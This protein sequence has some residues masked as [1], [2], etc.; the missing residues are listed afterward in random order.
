MSN[1]RINMCI[2]RRVVE[3]EQLYIYGLYA[4]EDSMNLLELQHFIVTRIIAVVVAVYITNL[5]V[6][7]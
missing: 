2:Q 3:C 4:D 6:I 5:C 7:R 1:V